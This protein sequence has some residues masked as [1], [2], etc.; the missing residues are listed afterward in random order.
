MDG[1][2]GVLACVNDPDIGVRYYA[3]RTLGN[4]LIHCTDILLPKL[5]SEQIVVT[6]TECLLQYS[7]ANS[8]WEN[9]WEA[10]QTHLALRT[11]TTEALAQ[12]LRHLRT[13]SSAANLPSR[14]K[15]SIL[16]HF[17]KPEVLNAVWRGAQN[18]KGRLTWRLHR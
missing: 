17:A 7:Q 4:M 18:A 10:S 3:V 15:R 5:M 12:V 13:P 11:T 9:D 1:V 2:E 16:L 8:G 6:L 14:L